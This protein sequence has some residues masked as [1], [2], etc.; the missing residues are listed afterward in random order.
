[1]SCLD[2]DIGVGVNMRILKSGPGR[3]SG[4]GHRFRSHVL[5]WGQVPSSNVGS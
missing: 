5:A 4:S 3:V 2:L 1:M